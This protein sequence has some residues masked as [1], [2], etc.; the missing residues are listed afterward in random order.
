MKQLLIILLLSTTA[1]SQPL[2]GVIYDFEIGDVLETKYR[3]WGMSYANTEYR[4]DTIA[5]KEITSDTITYTINRNTYGTSQAGTNFN[6][7]TEYL[8]VLVNQP[9]IFEP[10]YSCLPT[11]DSS[12]I[13]ECDQNYWYRE[14]YIDTT[15][16][17]I[18]PP[19]W[20]STLI[21]GL[22][23]PYYWIYDSKQTV[24]NRT[25]ELIY[26][27]TAK[28]GVCGKYFWPT[29]ELSEYM[30]DKKQLVKII[31]YLGRE[32]EDK[33][34]THLIYVYSDGTTEKVYRM[35]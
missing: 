5:D 34:N 19:I 11:T 14:T 27:N 22:G 26:S 8:V 35:E 25:L 4:L 12:F 30:L 33:P 9:A 31:D 28:N 23:G 20:S 13:G 10:I 7:S 29:A 15:M 17:D 21:E 2:Q 1:V 6:Q 32:T 24:T 18:S 16:C 3:A